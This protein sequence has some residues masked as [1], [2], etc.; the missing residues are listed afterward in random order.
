MKPGTKFTTF[1]TFDAKNALSLNQLYIVE[2]YSAKGMKV[3][4]MKTDIK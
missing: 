2:D 1:I 3:E 4:F